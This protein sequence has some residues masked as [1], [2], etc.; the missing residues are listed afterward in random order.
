MQ[1][2][3]LDKLDRNKLISGG[4]TEDID[5]RI[6]MKTNDVTKTPSITKIYIEHKK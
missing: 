3:E 4:F 6:A 1:V 2:K 5:F